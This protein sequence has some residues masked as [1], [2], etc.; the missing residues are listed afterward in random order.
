[1]SIAGS[2]HGLVNTAAWVEQALCAQVDVGDLWYPEKGQAGAS[3]AK[4]VCVSCPVR[5]ACLAYALERHEQHG[6]WGGTTP[7]ERTRLR[8]TVRWSPTTHCINGHD[9][10]HAGQR[11]DGSCGQCRRNANRKSKGRAA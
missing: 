8:P 5:K 9:Y 4:A 11:S 6:I 10:T 3:A 1:M 7:N 2:L